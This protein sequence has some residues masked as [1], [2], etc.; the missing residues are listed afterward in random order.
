MVGMDIPS[1]CLL[2]DR[3]NGT[4]VLLRWSLFIFTFLWQNGLVISE[5]YVLDAFGLSPISASHEL[6]S[7]LS[8]HDLTS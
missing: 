6:C 7:L 2:A 8:M 1:L 3:E 4:G 5:K